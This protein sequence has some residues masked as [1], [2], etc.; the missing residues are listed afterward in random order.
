MHIQHHPSSLPRLTRPWRLTLVVMMF[1]VVLLPQPTQAAPSWKTIASLNTARYGHTVTLLPNGKVLVA[2]G[3]TGS[4]SLSSA[5]VYD[6]S[7]NTWTTVAS[8]NDAR[9]YHTATL[10][11]SGKVLVAGGNADGLAVLSSAEIYDPIA[12]TWTTVASLNTGRFSAAATL[13]PNGQVLV[14]GGQIWGGLWPTGLEEVYDPIANTWTIVAP[15]KT[16]RRNHTATLLPS[17]KV[18]VAGGHNFD[19]CMLTSA[20]VYDPSL[21]TWTTA[22][23]LSSARYGHTTTLLPSGKVLVVGGY[24][25]SSYNSSAEVYDP[26]AD[27]WV[28]VA[29]LNTA[30]AYHTATLL[31]SGKVLVAGGY[32]GSS[33]HTGAEVYDP[34]EDTWTTVASLN[35]A[36]MFGMATLLP[37]GKVLVAGGFNGGPLAI[38]EEYD[39]PSAGSWTTVTPLNTAHDYHTATLLPSGKVLVVGGQ[40]TGGSLNS[41]KVYNPSAN[42]WTSL[43]PLNTARYAHTA[44]LLPSGKVLVAG[45]YNGA[46]LDSAEVYNPSANT[47][48]TVAPL[49]T[50]RELHTATLLPN[51]KVFVAG[52][53][54]G[55]YLNSAEV[56]D[57]SANTWTTVAPLDTGRELHTATLLPNG[58]VLIAGGYNGAFLANAQV[59]DPNANSWTTVAPMNVSRYG[60]TATLLPSGKVLVAGGYNGDYLTSVEVYDSSANTWTSVAFLN[61][62]HYYHTATLLPNGKVLVV[63]GR[64]TGGGFFNSS[65]VYDPSANT[66]TSVAPLNA[67]RSIH[68]ATLLPNGQVLVVGGFDGTYLDSAEVYDRDLGFDEAWRPTV[69]SVTSPLT[70]GNALSLTGSGFRGY[71]FTEAGGGGYNSSATNYPLVQ[72]RRLDNE[73]LLWVPPSASSF[74][75]TS[76]TSLPVT[77]TLGGPALVTVFVN[78]IP[79]VSQPMS[80][81]AMPPIHYVAP[82]GQCGIK[83][84]CYAQVQ[85]AVDAANAGDEVYVAAGVYTDV[86][87]RDGTTQ[88]VYLDKSIILRGGYNPQTWALDPALNK[89]ILDAQGLGSVLKITGVITPEIESLC[90]TNGSA[91]YGGG[92]YIHTAAATLRLNEIYSNTATNWGGGVYLENSPTWIVNNQIYSNTT[93]SNGRGGGVALLN[94]P[95]T[96][97]TNT[98][99]ANRAHVGGGI[100]LQNSAAGSGA[101]LFNNMIRDNTAFDYKRDDGYI[102]DGAGGGVDIGSGSTDTLESNTI[103]SNTAKRGGGVHAYNAPVIIV[104]NTIQENYAPYHGGGLYVQGNQPTIDYNRILSNTA[105][106]WGG[107]LSLWVDQATV[108][109]NTFQGNV[110]GWRGGGMYSQSAAEFDGNLFMENTAVEQGGGIFIYRDWKAV[111][112]NNVVVNNHAAQGGGV[113]LWGTESQFIHTTINNNSSTDEN[114]VVI[115]KYPGLVDPGEPEQ[116]LSNVSFINT[117]W[118]NQTVGLY[119]TPANT[120]TVNSVLWYNIPTHIQAA[121]A[122]LTVLN[123]YTGDPAFSFDGYHLGNNSAACEKGENVALDHD[124][125]GQLRPV[126]LGYDLGAD[127]AMLRVLID[128]STGGSVTYG[129]PQQNVTIT[130]DVPPNAVPYSVELELSPLPPP[131]PE[132]LPIPTDWLFGPPFGLD[133]FLLDTVLPGLT[134]TEPATVTLTYS[135]EMEKLNEGMKFLE[136]QLI[137]IIGSDQ[138]KQNAACGPEKYDLGKNIFEA[139]ICQL[140]FAPTRTTRTTPNPLRSPENYTN[141]YAFIAETNQSY[142][143][144]TSLD[145]PPITYNANGVVTVTVSATEATPTGVVTLSVDGG[146]PITQTLAPVPSS[147]PPKAAATFTLTAPCAGAHTLSASYVEQGNF[148]ASSANGTLNVNQASTTTTLSSSSNPSTFGETVTFTA[149]VVSGVGTWAG[150]VTFKNGA[151]T[152]SASTL[153]GGVV[154]F[155]TATL[156]GGTHTIT[157]EYSGEINYSSSVSDALPQRVNHYVYLPVVLR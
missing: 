23:S 24:N 81:K 8:L 150:T 88:A 29:P 82:L 141:I 51:G 69:N 10:L 40:T 147:T 118:A 103:R 28:T 80:V 11:P 95:A 117:I 151:A 144:S 139:P 33:Y 47:W 113:Y 39:D 67:A 121:G 5:E 74:N 120:L 148:T 36:F 93:G 2:G 38:A 65:E 96:L 58:K 63:G 71:L 153:S 122:A 156:E 112:T 1:F 143:T 111:Y 98:I 131:L 87:T 90:L 84:P 64:T 3:Y 7:A 115:D 128:P 154:T 102:F 32:N 61:T 77:N 92:V 15:L 73:Q 135:E 157:A 79:S 43:A 14:T 127:E 109:G 97:E 19:C 6:P 31:P 107:G 49:N 114:G 100:E 142:T 138:F 16:V 48:T 130:V 20:E 110:A 56:Y 50:A 59:Y 123:E 134:L 66:W 145:A 101:L 78:G 99:N 149:T 116:T 54:N 106:S 9:Y 89:T 35:T 60:H 119:S 68:T 91:P 70:L 12:N 4:D 62:A 94:S 22:A 55:A 45:G 25:G 86:S 133:T 27:T 129:D 105:D 137:A 18:L 155:S 34:I 44:T 132:D 75:D 104:Q 57:P 108:S 125:D 21:N 37:G 13:L 140:G 72:I 42:T 26:S 41:T 76:F 146:A 152:L 85:T 53:Y 52:G 46:F 17:G 30:H 124:V 136:M 83:S 126:N